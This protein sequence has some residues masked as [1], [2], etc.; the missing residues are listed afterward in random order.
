[1]I[2]PAYKYFLWS[3]VIL[4]PTI[5]VY[6]QEWLFWRVTY[7]PERFGEN[8]IPQVE[9]AALVAIPFL[10]L[11]I[12]VSWKSQFQDIKKS[13]VLSAALLG[14]TLNFLLYGYAFYDGYVYWRD[15][16]GTGANIGLGILM[17][18]SPIWISLVMFGVRRTGS[19]KKEGCN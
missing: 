11:A 10:I 14:I 9:R 6:L 5:F 3:L 7:R 18:L 16:P 13:T 4:A 1:M 8:P 12:R 2:S 17:L 19:A 15:R